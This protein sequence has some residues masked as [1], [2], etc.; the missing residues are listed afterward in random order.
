MAKRI[1]ITDTPK[2]QIRVTDVPKRR[3]EPS[4]AAKALGAEPCGNQIGGDLDPILLAELGNKVVSRLRSSGGRPALSDATELCRVPLS[5]QD[6]EALSNITA[7]IEH[8]T[9]L[10]PSPGQ[11]ASTILRD[12]LSASSKDRAAAPGM[13]AHTGPTERLRT[14][15]AGATFFSKPNGRAA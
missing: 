4:E 5:E 7:R 2:R 8:K 9:G 1:K 11:V 12:Y 13:P 15:P 14:R 3:I 10:K 6:M